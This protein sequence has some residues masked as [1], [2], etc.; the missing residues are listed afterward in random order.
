[1]ALTRA[2]LYDRARRL[3]GPLMR[4]GIK[5]PALIAGIGLNVLAMPMLPAEVPVDRKELVAHAG[6]TAYSWMGGDLAKAE[7]GLRELLTAYPNAPGVHY[8][9]AT[10]LAASHP[11]EAMA[12]FQRE[13]ATNPRSAEARAMIALLLLGN[14]QV[15]PAMPYAVKAFTDLPG[16]PLTLYAYGAALSAAGD[17][18]QAIEHLETAARL[19]P[20]NLDD[21]I[22]LAGAYARAGRHTE[23]R[24]ER[25]ASID[26]ARE[27]LSSDRF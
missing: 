8:F 2:G 13:L 18:R 25:Q 6:T 10:F 21:H 16:S 3:F 11:D 14:S 26:L 27:S 15:S 22:A 7:T 5:D 24:R 19:D 17:L 1:L 23:A 9:Y 12:E 20:S 4:R